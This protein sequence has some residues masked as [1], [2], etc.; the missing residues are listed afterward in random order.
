MHKQNGL[1]QPKLA[2]FFPGVPI[3]TCYEDYTN[4]GKKTV[5]N[6]RQRVSGVLS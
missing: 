6:A 5:V 3:C 1:V 4:A 2:V